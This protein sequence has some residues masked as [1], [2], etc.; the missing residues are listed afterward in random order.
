ML[1]GLGIG[2]LDRTVDGLS[3]GEKRRVALAAALVGEPDLLVLD[4]PTNHLDVEGMRWLAE[5]LL[6]RRSALVVVTHDRWFLDTVC[7]RT[8]EVA[9]GTVESYEGGYAD[10]IFAR[11]ERAR[12]ADAAE[13]R[14][15]QP[16]PQGAGL[17]A[18]RARR[19]ARRSRATGS[20]R[21]RR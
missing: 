13:A 16:G 4:E 5:H 7:T 18:P 19:R 12:Q 17:A 20:R 6:A 21:P 3:G 11:A 10:W 2:D 15:Q 1:D 9:G 8:W 14:R